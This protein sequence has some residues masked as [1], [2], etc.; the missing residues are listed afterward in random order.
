MKAMILKQPQQRLQPSDVGTPSIKENEVLVE[1]EACGVCRTD[2]HILDGELKN[3]KLPLIPGHEIV[4]KVVQLGNRVKGFKEG[5]RVGVP[6]LAYTCGKC[7]FCLRGQENLC[8]NAI[9]TGYTKD[10]GYGEYVVADENYCFAVPEKFDSISLAPLLCAGLIGWRSYRLA[11]ECKRLGM[12]G[13]GGAAHIL[14]QIAHAQG[15]EIYAFTRP[16]DEK[17]QKFALQLGAV[18]A[19][20][21]TQAPPQLLD[22]SIVF[23]PAGPLV[24][25]ALKSSRKGGAIICG[26]IHMSDIPPIPYD[27]LWGE[28]IIRS[29]ANLTREDAR[30]FFDT[31]ERIPLKTSVTEYKLEQANQALD[32]LRAT[33]FEGAAVLS[34]KS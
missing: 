16:G 22:A 5:Q 6:W 12:Y 18:W 2:L 13:F 17:G 24:L 1:V 8:D 3:A 31:V 27:L 9:F 10:G 33:R 14:T 11:G 29:V 4:G 21:S 23:A 20:D 32:D 15:K 34:I 25:S 19:G 28:R 7:S 30:T 26:G